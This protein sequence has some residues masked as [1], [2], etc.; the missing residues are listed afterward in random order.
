MNGSLIKWC[1]DIDHIEYD[2][3]IKLLFYNNDND[4]EKK[5]HKMLRRK[6]ETYV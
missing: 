5:S 1:L 2:S 6:E 4:D 3:S